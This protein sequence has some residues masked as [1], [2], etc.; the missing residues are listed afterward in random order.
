MQE[1]INNAW[2]TLANAMNNLRLKANKE[3]LEALLDEVSGLNLDQYTEE[4]AAAFRSALASA[5]AVFADNTLSEEDQKTVDNA[6]AALIS[7]K[8]ALVQ[9]DGGTDPEA[10]ENPAAPGSGSDGNGSGGSSASGSDGAAGD[11]QSAE[12]E[13][14][15][16]QT[17]DPASVLMTAGIM[18]MALTAVIII[19]RKKRGM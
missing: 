6:A 9:K 17:G 3:A 12:K 1:E 15:A 10:P 7:A 19:G 8:D 2:N 11:G 18:M 4:S 16:V 5:Q 14:G 13:T